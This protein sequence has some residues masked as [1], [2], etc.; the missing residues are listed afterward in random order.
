LDTLP[1]HI[2][3]YGGDLAGL[4]GSEDAIELELAVNILLL[5]LDVGRS[6][7]LGR[8]DDE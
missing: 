8:H 2:V 7:D 4:E 6:V 1:R 3:T 5:D